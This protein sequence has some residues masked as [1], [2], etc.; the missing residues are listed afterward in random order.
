[1]REIVIPALYHGETSY[2]VAGLSAPAF[3][4]GFR[5]SGQH[6]SRRARN[7]ATSSLSWSI[8]SPARLAPK[9]VVSDLMST[10]ALPI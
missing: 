4:L 8:Y 2:G 3:G 7:S 6:S 5:S 10:V 1:M 9:S